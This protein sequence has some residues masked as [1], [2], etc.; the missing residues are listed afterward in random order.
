[1]LCIPKISEVINFFMPNMKNNAILEKALHIYVINV[2]VH[3]SV[4]NTYNLYL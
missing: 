2:H 3:I 1:M 4:H